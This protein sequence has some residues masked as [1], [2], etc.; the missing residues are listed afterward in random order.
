VFI[1]KIGAV[2]NGKRVNRSECHCRGNGTIST[3]RSA[4]VNGGKHVYCSE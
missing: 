2:G 3:D 4:A 1:V